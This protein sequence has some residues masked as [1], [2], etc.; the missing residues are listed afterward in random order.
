MPSSEV[1]MSFRHTFVLAILLAIPTAGS[2]VPTSYFVQPFE[3]A[4]STSA[5]GFLTVDAEPDLLDQYPD[6]YQMTG[7]TSTTPSFASQAVIDVGL[8]GNFDDGANGITFS[9]LS[10]IYADA[11]RAQV[12]GGVPLPTGGSPQLAGAY[13]DV[14]GFSIVLDSP[15][16]AALTPGVNPNEYLWAG[17]ANV[18]V[19]GTLATTFEVPTVQTVSTP[20]QPFNQS[21]T[22]ILAG[23]FSGD[24]TSTEVTV[25]IPTDDLQNL[26]LSLPPQSETLD[27]GIAM[28]SFDFS[29]FII[30]DASGAVVYRNNT[31]PIPEPGTAALLGLGLLGLA[32]RKRNA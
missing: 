10:I 21:L 18:T 15:F 19:S 12:L 23:T 26:N 27:L 31:V 2:A 24:A 13:Y 14:D 8:P 28:L 7:N 4:I 3:S 32:S 5:S 1:S 20:P 9:T 25:G 11:I 16:T 17:A 6:F 22:V 30:A 29:D